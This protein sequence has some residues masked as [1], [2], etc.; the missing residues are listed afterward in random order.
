MSLSSDRRAIGGPSARLINQA[1]REHGIIGNPGIHLPLIAR[2]C[3]RTHRGR[4]EAA[5]RGCASGCPRGKIRTADAGQRTAP[6]VS[7]RR[8]RASATTLRFTPA[9]VGLTRNGSSVQGTGGKCR[10]ADGTAR[11]GGHLA[12]GRQGVARRVVACLACSLL[13]ALYDREYIAAASSLPP[14]QLHAL[15]GENANS[16]TTVFHGL[17][18]YDT[19]SP[20]V[21]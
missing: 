21:T 20:S 15:T 4:T 12:A 7:P 11:C 13:V 5:G 18:L 8:N 19:T 6:A 14:P 1:S 2:P 16:P 10:S 17:T 9:T 3:R